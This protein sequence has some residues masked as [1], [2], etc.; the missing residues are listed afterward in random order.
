MNNVNIK[1]I[2]IIFIILMMLNQSVN[3]NTQLLIL[4]TC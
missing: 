2:I 4:F 1:L 3:K